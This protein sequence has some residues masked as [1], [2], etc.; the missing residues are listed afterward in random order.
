MT[1]MEDANPEL[2][3]NLSTISSSNSYVNTDK[4]LILDK[5]EK[6]TDKTS[7]VVY[8]EVFNDL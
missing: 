2:E 4:L 1:I 6:S 8:K 3:P 5:D 7:N